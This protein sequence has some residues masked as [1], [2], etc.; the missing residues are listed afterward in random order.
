[1]KQFDVFAA[2]KRT[3]LIEGLLKVL[4]WNLSFKQSHGLEE[5]CRFDGRI[6]RGVF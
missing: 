5:Q 4:V 1:M 3:D 6:N 2:S